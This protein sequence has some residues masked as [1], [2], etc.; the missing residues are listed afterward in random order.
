[1]IKKLK[2]STKRLKL[3][4]LKKGELGPYIKKLRKEQKLT[5]EALAASAGVGLRFIRELEQG[6]D[7][8]HLGK[9]MMVL[10]L[11]G[12]RLYLEE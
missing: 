11:L 10:K 8:C 3:L 5:Q 6:K 4:Q 12:V 2:N 9:T 7:S 1:M